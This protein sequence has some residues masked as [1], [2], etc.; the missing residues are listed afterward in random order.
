[1]PVVLI[2]AAAGHRRA[3]CSAQKQAAVLADKDTVIA[4]LKAQLA[5]AASSQK[6]SASG[7]AGGGAAG[8]PARLANPE[9]A[10]PAGAGAGGPPASISLAGD[11]SEASPVFGEDA[12]WED[13]P[14]PNTFRQALEQILMLQVCV[15]VFTSAWTCK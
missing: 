8:G 9:G 15:R 7:G 5:Q 13:M 11:S 2:P 1:V 14:V 10:V 12:E 6:S 3:A 4:S